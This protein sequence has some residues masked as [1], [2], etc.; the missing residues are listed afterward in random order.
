MIFKSW[1]QIL[2]V[3]NDQLPTLCAVLISDCWATGSIYGFL[4]WKR[5]FPHTGTL[6]WWNPIP[7]LLLLA[8]ILH[9]ACT[10]NFIRGHRRFVGGW[11]WFGGGVN[12]GFTTPN[13]VF[14]WRTSVHF[15]GRHSRLGSRS[16]GR[17]SRNVYS[18]ACGRWQR[19]H[20]VLFLLGQW[21]TWLEDSATR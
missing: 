3:L 8:I 21:R 12:W 9:A 4:K 6:T 2:A 11:G 13:A 16:S 19:G 10:L 5:P 7:I 20:A 18:T 14:P 1:L 15:I 17:N